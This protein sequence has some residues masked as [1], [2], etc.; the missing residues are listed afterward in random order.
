MIHPNYI[1]KPE[2]STATAI[3]DLY[4]QLADLQ[5]TVAKLLEENEQ[6]TE[7]IDS[8]ESWRTALRLRIRQQNN[9]L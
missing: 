4:G 1:S 5:A 3:G 9:V 6:L 2:Q 7:R 8:M